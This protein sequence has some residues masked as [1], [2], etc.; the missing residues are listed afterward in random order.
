MADLFDALAARALGTER[1]LNPVLAPR[2]ADQP[3]NGLGEPSNEPAHA[4]V[5]RARPAAARTPERTAAHSGEEQPAARHPSDPPP[6]RTLWTD[7][8]DEPVPRRE[9][10][11]PPDR[12][13]HTA[14]PAPAPVG[15]SGEPEPPRRQV[16]H[17]S[18][19]APAEPDRAQPPPPR[20]P[21]PDVEPPRGPAPAM[22]A[23]PRLVTPPPGEQSLVPPAARPPQD[24]APEDDASPRPAGYRTPTPSVQVT[25]W[26]GA[27]EVRAPARPAAPPPPR[28]PRWPQPRLSLQDY[29]RDGRR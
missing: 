8:S 9:R 2:F 27:V 25:V 14:A 4:P 15:T 10:Q 29:L 13:D 26:I 12:P 24:L 23:E 17:P 1:A 6:G 21:Q 16:P 22:P 18:A 5:D 20:R 28:Q 11:L 19:E 3:D 7:A